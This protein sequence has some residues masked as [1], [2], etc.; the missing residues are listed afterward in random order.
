MVYQ[1]PKLINELVDYGVGSLE[2]GTTGR[3][4]KVG[5]QNIGLYMQMQRVGR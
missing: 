5:I 3:V 2:R 1:A 4:K